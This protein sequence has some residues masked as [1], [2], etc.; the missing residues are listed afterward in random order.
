M[1]EPEEKPIACIDLVQGLL[2]RQRELLHDSRG[3]AIVYCR[4]EPRERGGEIPDALYGLFHVAG[5]GICVSH[6]L[7]PRLIWNSAMVMTPK[8][9]VGLHLIDS[10]LMS[11]LAKARR[12]FERLHT[13]QTEV[14]LQS[15]KR[16]T[17]FLFRW[18]VPAR[19]PSAGLSGSG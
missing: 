4:R 2:D 10:P 9:A 11:R 19:S 13:S 17:E 16:L 15:A 7:P 8:Q 18:S 14:L 6:D 1:M 5:G 12:W 3:L